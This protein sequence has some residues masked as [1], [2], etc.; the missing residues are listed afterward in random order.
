MPSPSSTLEPFRIPHEL[1]KRLDNKINPI[2]RKMHY[3][4]TLQGDYTCSQSTIL[5]TTNYHGPHITRLN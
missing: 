4:Y 1:T 3:D 2:K 5:T